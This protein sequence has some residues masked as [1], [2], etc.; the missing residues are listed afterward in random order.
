M[1]HALGHLID[2]SA[3]STAPMKSDVWCSEEVTMHE[4]EHQVLDAA[5]GGKLTA[6][7]DGI[8][9]RTAATRHPVARIEATFASV[10]DAD[11]EAYDD[12]FGIRKAGTETS[13]IYLAQFLASLGL[14]LAD[15]L[16]PEDERQPAKIALY[17][18]NLEA[19]ML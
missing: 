10:T 17:R 18:A 16:Y 1:G 3:S 7:I 15:R 11:L 9:G 8:I 5:A 2:H 6:L 14:R 12:L 4:L 19:W 13:G